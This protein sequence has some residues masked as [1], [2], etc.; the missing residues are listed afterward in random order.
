MYLSPKFWFQQDGAPSHRSKPTIRYIKRYVSPQILPHP[1][2]S[3]DINPIELIWARMKKEVERK[4]PTKKEDLRNA[5]ITSWQN[6]DLK[7]I[8]KC[9]RGLKKIMRRIVKNNGD[10]IH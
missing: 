7:L 4:R 10:L 1:A 9:I 6:L 8:R 2:Q 5:I 3:P